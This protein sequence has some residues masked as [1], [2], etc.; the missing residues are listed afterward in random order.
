MGSLNWFISLREPFFFGSRQ[1][2]SG[3]LCGS[4]LK[5]KV[6]TAGSE[7]CAISARRRP[8]MDPELFLAVAFSRDDTVAW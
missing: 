5:R 4:R 3:A 8:D 6:V 7:R 1:S 2:G